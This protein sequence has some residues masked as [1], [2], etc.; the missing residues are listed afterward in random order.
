MFTKNVSIPFTISEAGNGYEL[1]GEFS[2]N[3]LDYGLGESSVILSDMVIVT[4]A[5]TAKK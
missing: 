4:I 2:I 1:K 5:V 3:R